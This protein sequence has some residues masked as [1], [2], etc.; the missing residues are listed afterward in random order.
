MKNSIPER[1]TLTR[2]SAAYYEAFVRA[3]AQEIQ[4][5]NLQFP[6][7]RLSPLERWGAAGFR[8]HRS[9]PLLYTLTALFNIDGREISYEIL[10]QRRYRGK[11]YA[12]S[13]FYGF[14]LQDPG[15]VVLTKGKLP[16]TIEEASRRLIL[17]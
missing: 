4:R 7:R 6:D 3:V 5:F 10:P 8:V 14:L 9:Y 17:L 2:L 13:G 12:A 16:I 1:D 11:V 15:Q